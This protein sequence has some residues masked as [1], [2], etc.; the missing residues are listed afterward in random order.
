MC[1]NRFFVHLRNLA[2]FLLAAP[3][4]LLLVV[5]SY[6]FQPQR[7]WLTL[8]LV[9]AACVMAVLLRLYVQMERNDVLSKIAGSSPTASTSNWNFL[10]SAFVSAIPLLGVIAATSSDLSDFIHSSIDPLLQVLR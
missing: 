8:I 10:S 5:T 7:L 3:L 2:W 4:L 1:L 9:L 6:P